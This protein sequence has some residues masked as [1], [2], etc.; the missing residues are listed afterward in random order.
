MCC[1]R[2]VFLLWWLSFFTTKE[3]KHYQHH[4]QNVLTLPEQSSGNGPLFQAEDNFYWNNAAG[5]LG[6]ATPH[7][8]YYQRITAS[9]IRP[10]LTAHNCRTVIVPLK[11]QRRERRITAQLVPA[12]TTGGVQIFKVFQD[13]Q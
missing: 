6:R 7:G 3:Y 12:A 9:T 11:W 5:W 1:G 8:H 13:T 2:A 4:G 10:W